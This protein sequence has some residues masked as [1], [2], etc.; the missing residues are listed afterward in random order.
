[1]TV[2]WFEENALC[3]LRNPMIEDIWIL[4]VCLAN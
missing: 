3:L 1:M 2:S 4:S